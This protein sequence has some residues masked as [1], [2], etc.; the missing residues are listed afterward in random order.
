MLLVGRKIPRSAHGPDE[1]SDQ[2]QAR[3]TRRGLPVEK[4]RE[5]VARDVRLRSSERFGSRLEPG[6]DIIRQ[7]QRDCPHGQ[8]IPQ[9]PLGNTTVLADDQVIHRKPATA[10]FE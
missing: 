3:D 5:R 4:A 9:W 2:I 7:L 1:I 8:I 10:T 6:I